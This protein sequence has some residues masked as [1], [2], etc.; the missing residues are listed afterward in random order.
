M[1]AN[2]KKRSKG[3]TSLAVHI[4]QLSLICLKY[5]SKETWTRA[6]EE[7]EL[8]VKRTFTEKPGFD[9]QNIKI[10]CYT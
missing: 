4:M 3:F 5:V 9:N 2:N 1:I 6:I 7:N 8:K 10:I